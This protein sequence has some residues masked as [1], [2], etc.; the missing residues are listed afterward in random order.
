MQTKQQAFCLFE[1]TGALR[2]KWRHLSAAAS[3]A[4]TLNLCQGGLKEAGEKRHR[5]RSEGSYQAADT[6]AG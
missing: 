1:F 6:E 2:G 4:V 5:R 3:P